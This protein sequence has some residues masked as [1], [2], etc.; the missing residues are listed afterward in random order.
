MTARR[1]AFRKT[2]NNGRN[3]ANSTAPLKIVRFSDGEIPLE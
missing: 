3:R 1:E 2:K